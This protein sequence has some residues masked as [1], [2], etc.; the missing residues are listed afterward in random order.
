MRR[1]VLWFL[2]TVSVGRAALRLPHLDEQDLV[3]VGGERR[4]RPVLLSAGSPR[5][6]RWARSNSFRL[7]LTVW[8]PR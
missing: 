8:R 6:P 7:R 3:R 1:I 2:T 4:S 5:L